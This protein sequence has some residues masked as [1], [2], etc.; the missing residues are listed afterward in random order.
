MTVRPR[1]RS[2]GNMRIRPYH[3]S[4]LEALRELTILAFE[5]VGIDHNIEKR[6]GMIQG[7]DWRWRKARHIDEDAAVNP[8]GIFVAEN[9]G[10]I[11]GYVTTRVDAEA[12]VGLIPN[13]AVT[14]DARG[15]GLGRLLIEC[16]LDYFRSQGLALAR[17]ETLDQNPIGQHLYPACGFHE[18]ARQIHYV[19]PLTI[20]GA[21]DKP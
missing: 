5:G 16:A 4:D 12:G 7:H 13:L 10:R 8:K 18:V 14:A 20:T 3:P 11:M 9:D 2:Q 15:R 6:F 21:G 1:Q 17:I 19:R